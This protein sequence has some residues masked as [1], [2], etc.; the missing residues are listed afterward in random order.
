M[1]K[2][3]VI[4][5][6]S[7]LGKC[8]LTAAI[9]VISAM[10]IQACPLPTAVL[11]N[12]TGY[13]SYFLD[14]YTP[15]MEAIMEQ[16]QLRGF[17]PDGIYT[18]FLGSSAQADILLHFFAQ[19]QTPQT[20]TLVDPV[21][22]D[23]GHTYDIFCDDFLEK[24]RLLV[25]RA[26][27]IT[28]NLTEALLLLYGKEGMRNKYKKL[29]KMM[30]EDDPTECR[31]EIE[32]TARM[33]LHAF[34]CTTAVITGIPFGDCFADSSISLAG[35]SGAASNTCSGTASDN[36]TGNTSGGTIGTLLFQKDGSTWFTNRRIGGCFS[37][38]GDLFAS[39]L[40]AGLVKGL[41]A[42]I[43]IQKA[44]DFLSQGI[45]DAAAEGTDPND[46]ICFEPYLHLLF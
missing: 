40:I 22:G 7:G 42:A 41:P 46:G 18:G 27:V 30:Q 1:K 29:R 31:T 36:S 37:G 9:P 23:D 6:L 33:L 32:Q 5:D 3:A 10:G 17:T 24:M 13:A 14:D 20:I 25:G 12:Q 34:G 35:N 45:R 28:P 26:Q 2:I 16:W 19:F 38:T 8:S 15:H 39:V 44:I 11:S 21:M 4:N 43:C